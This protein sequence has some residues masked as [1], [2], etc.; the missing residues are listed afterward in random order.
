MAT[1]VPVFSLTSAY[2][3]STF[4]FAPSDRRRAVAQDAP[5]WLIE[6]TV[7]D[8]LVETTAIRMFPWVGVAPSVNARL[9]VL[10]A[11]AAPCPSGSVDTAATATL[12]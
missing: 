12:G 7:V 8:E 3:I 6:D 4:A 9:L 10:A 5:D 2:Q 1:L 11:V